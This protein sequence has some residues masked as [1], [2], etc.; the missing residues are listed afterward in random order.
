MSVLMERQKLIKIVA[1]QS[2]DLLDLLNQVV[3]SGDRGIKLESLYF[4]KGQRVTI[5][6]QA[7]GNEQLYRFE[8]NLQ[9]RNSIK[10]VKMS[11]TRDA[12]SK[13]LKF[14][15]TFHYKNFTK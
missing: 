5:N 1:L 6:G 8:K 13:K 7:P 3:E 9:D 14:T 12:K 4:K 11:S 2:P 15:I 10:D